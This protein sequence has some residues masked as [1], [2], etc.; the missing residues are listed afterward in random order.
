MFRDERYFEC[1]KDCAVFVGLDKL[2]ESR[3]AIISKPQKQKSV[4]QQ[5]KQ[6]TIKIGDRVMAFDNDGGTVHGTVR[7]TGG[8]IGSS[9]FIG[10]ETVSTFIYTASY[11]VSI[12]CVYFILV[13]SYLYTPIL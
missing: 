12:I 11:M 7:W 13:C 8:S 2:S 3:S 6:N 10:I 9:I 1:D 4:E 5:Q